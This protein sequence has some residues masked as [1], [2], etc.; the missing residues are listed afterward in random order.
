[1]NGPEVENEFHLV[2]T[3]KKYDNIRNSSN[4][5]LKNLFNLNTTTE[6]K[7]KL[8]EHAM[9]SDNPV[10]VNLLS[11][12]IQGRRNTFEIGGAEFLEAPP[13]LAPSGKFFEN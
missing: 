7:Q 2:F 11:K 5:I 1:M 12:F 8:L 6:S 4:N 10:L 9:S 13:W 3:C